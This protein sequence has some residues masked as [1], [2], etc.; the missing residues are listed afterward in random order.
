MANQVNDIEIFVL[1]GGQS[2]R[3][4]QDKGQMMVNGQA[5]IQYLLSTLE[6][7]PVSISIVSNDPAYR[8]FGYPVYHD[9]IANQGPMGGLLTALENSQYPL[10]LLLAC[11]YPFLSAEWIQ[12]LMDKRQR[13][14]IIVPVSRSIL[15]PLCA[16]Y[17]VEILDKVRDMIQANVL[18]MKTLI[19]SFPHCLVDIDS[20]VERDEF[21]MTNVNTPE[22][23]KQCQTR[24]KVQ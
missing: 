11:D 5:L 22:E 10:I 4:G 23:L 3:M 16:I 15:H 21:L 19:Q 18:K 14:Q 9:S 1:A 20:W 12:W 17:P 6:R 24:W 13:D 8:Q 7:I 2:S